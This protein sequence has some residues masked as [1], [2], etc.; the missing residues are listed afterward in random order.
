MSRLVNVSVKVPEEVRRL[1]KRVNVN[2]SEYL[3]QVIEAKIREEI[4]KE[5]A[6]KLD[7]IRRRSGEV[8]TEEIV[9]WI[10]EDREKSLG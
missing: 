8:S 6:E 4:A 9:K 3:R 2:W 5:A 10:R 7:E 1:M